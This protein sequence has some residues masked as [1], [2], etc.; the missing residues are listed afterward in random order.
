MALVR[1]RDFGGP[2]WLWSAL[3][4]DLDMSRKKLT[5]F[6]GKERNEYQ[7]EKYKDF[8]G[9]WNTPG[10]SDD[11]VA[12]TYKTQYEAAQ[13]W[14]DRSTSSF[15]WLIEAMMLTEATNKEISQEMGDELSP[16]S[17]VCYHE[18]FFDIKS[19]QRKPVWMQKYIWATATQSDP[20][21]YYVDT[22]YKLLA[23]FG[24]KD[25]LGALFCATMPSTENKE[26]VGKY[27]E[28]EFLKKSLQFSSNYA[29]LD[30]CTRNSIHDRVMTDIQTSNA[31][32]AGESNESTEVMAKLAETL[33]GGMRMIDM[34]RKMGS[35]ET[36]AVDM[37]KNEDIKNGKDA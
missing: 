27:L 26:W 3:E 6:P 36:V 10:M 34:D 12:E 29:K 17:V 2:S 33:A 23:H 30:V 9:M 18:L 37:Y 1:H 21:I 13:V 16:A 22:I 31:K 25:L 11:E 8:F 35:K 5:R 32:S 14:Q 7:I 28:S 4:H 15:K 19:K 24:G 20:S